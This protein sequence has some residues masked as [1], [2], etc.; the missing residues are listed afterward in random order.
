MPMLVPA[1]VDAMSLVANIVAYAPTN[2]HAAA[3]NIIE[4]HEALGVVTSSVRA[5]A[6]IA[7]TPSWRTRRSHEIV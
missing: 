6:M 3:T 4:L 7:A 1:A 2:A 5:W